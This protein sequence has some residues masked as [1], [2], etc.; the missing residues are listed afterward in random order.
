M[1]EMKSVHLQVVPV[2]ELSPG[3][4]KK[5]IS[6]FCRSKSGYLCIN[7]ATATLWQSDNLSLEAPFDEKD[8]A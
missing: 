3:Q 5:R 7:S 2:P 6:D 8:E 4:L 1:V